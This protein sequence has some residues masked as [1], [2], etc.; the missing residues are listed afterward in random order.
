LEAITNNPQI[1]QVELSEITG[2]TRRG[3]EYNLSKLKEEGLIKRVGSDKD[4]S[5]K[6][7]GK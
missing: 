4:G 6:V 3:V 7:L 2:L 1:T 5:W